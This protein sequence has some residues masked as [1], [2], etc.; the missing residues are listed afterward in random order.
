MESGIDSYGKMLG[1]LEKFYN[2][3][4]VRLNRT[5]KF[6]LFHIDNFSDHTTGSSIVKGIIVSYSLESQSRAGI[7]DIYIVSE[8]IISCPMLQEKKWDEFGDSG[9]NGL[10]YLIR[11][12]VFFDEKKPIYWFIER[13]VVYVRRNC[14]EF[15]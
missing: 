1:Q 9:G 15:S 12:P 2:R 3:S 8:R 6:I 5:D 7:P 14:E 13:S 11:A 10:V 4:D